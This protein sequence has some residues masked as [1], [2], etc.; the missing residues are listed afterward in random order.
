[1][2][3]QLKSLEEIKGKTIVDTFFKDYMNTGYIVFEDSFIELKYE[4]GYELGDGGIIVQQEIDPDRVYV[5][6]GICT[7]KEFQQYREDESKKYK[8]E[9]RKRREEMYQRL[10]EEFEDEP[11]SR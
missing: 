11:K 8:E 6:L 2:K 3:R 7:E 9:N 4:Q 5:D 10:K 1:M